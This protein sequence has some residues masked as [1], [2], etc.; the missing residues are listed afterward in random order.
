MPYFRCDRCAV[1]LYS[2]ASRTHCSECGRSLARAEPLSEASPLPRPLRD[3]YPTAMQ[4]V[5][6]E[7]RDSR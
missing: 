4:S 3:R 2:A 6:G 7:R 1:R 5:V